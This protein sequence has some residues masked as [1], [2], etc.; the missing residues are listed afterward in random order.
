MIPAALALILT[1]AQVTSLRMAYTIGAPYDLGYTVSAI[2]WQESSFCQQK[3]NNWSVG[4]MGT[5]R[6]TVRFIFDP[7]A[8]RARLESDDVYSTQAGLSIL[9]YCRTST[10]NWSEMVYCFHFGLPQEEQATEDEILSDGYV[11]A[12]ARKVKELES[13][14]KDT[15]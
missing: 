8:T 4:C 1:Q 5:K 14:P 11:K 6:R 13:L 3:R 10:E 2:S 7:A 12:V 15:Q 9:L